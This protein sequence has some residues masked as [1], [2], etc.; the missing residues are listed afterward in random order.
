MPMTNIRL[1]PYSRRWVHHACALATATGLLLS[2]A[3]GAVPVQ[4]Q[5]A[6]LEVMDW[7]IHHGVDASGGNN[8][9]RV[10]NWIVTINPHVVSLNEVEKRNGYTDNADQPAI[11]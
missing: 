4:A 6:A 11:L 5:T 8:L 10:V 7:N 1:T 3:V 2:G 9:E